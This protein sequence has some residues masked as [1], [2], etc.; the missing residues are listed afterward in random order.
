[1]FKI[2]ST[3]FYVDQIGFPSSPKKFWP[4]SLFWPKFL[5]LS[6]N[7]EKK[8]GQRSFLG[9]FSKIFTKKIAFFRRALPPQISIF[10]RRRRFKKNFRVHQPKLDI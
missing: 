6:Q 2:L 9:T 4:K 7:F 1:M 8:T 10:W 5:R 3:F